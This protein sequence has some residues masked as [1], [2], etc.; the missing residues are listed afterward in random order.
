MDS[1]PLNG[2]R[3][4][5]LRLTNPWIVDGEEKRFKGTVCWR[6]VTEFLRYEFE[7]AGPFLHRRIVFQSSGVWAFPEIRSIESSDS[8]VEWARAPCV[9]VDDPKVCAE[10]KRLFGVDATVRDVMYS[11][12]SAKGVVVV[13]DKRKSMKGD[14]H[15]ARRC[16]KFWNGFG[17]NG[18]GQ[19]VH[20]ESNDDGDWRDR[21]ADDGKSSNVYVVDIFQY[22]IQGLDCALPCNA[23]TGK[24]RASDSDISVGK[25]KKVKS[26]DV[27]EDME[28]LDINSEYDVVGSVSEMEAP[29]RGNVKIISEMRLYWY[30]PK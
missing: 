5:A 15:G 26:E 28:K 2:V 19:V 9:G 6:G 17:K 11:R 21:L 14:E 7:A 22:G 25:R 27:D 13:E 29:L 24:K 1:V 30:E 10:L 8:D 12:I 4:R 18:N 23:P 20:Y 3:V 16:K